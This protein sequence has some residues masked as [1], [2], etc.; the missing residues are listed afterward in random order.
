MTKEIFNINDHSHVVH[1]TSAIPKKP[2]HTPIVIDL[3]SYQC[4]AGYAGI[5]NPQLAFDSIV[6]K[7]QNKKTNEQFF[8]AGNK[9]Y[10]TSTYS[11][12]TSKTI[13]DQSI[14]Y[15]FDFAVHQFKRFN[16]GAF[17]GPC[18]FWFRS[19]F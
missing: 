1:A 15:Q 12:I 17:D 18:V 8:T 3:G 4:R 13:H 2:G 11:K 9:H 6:H 14:I 7:Y 19:S 16:V 5:T 10:D